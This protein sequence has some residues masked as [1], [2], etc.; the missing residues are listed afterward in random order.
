MTMMRVDDSSLQVQCS[1]ST[2]CLVCWFA[3]TW[4]GVCI[5]HVNWVISHNNF[6]YFMEKKVYWLGVW[7]CSEMAQ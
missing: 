6:L 2:S 5:H 3:Y 1:F 4:S 7:L